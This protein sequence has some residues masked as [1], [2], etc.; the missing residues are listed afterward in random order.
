MATRCSV[1]WFGVA[2]WRTLPLCTARG[3]ILPLITKS[4]LW[5]SLLRLFY[6]LAVFLHIAGRLFQSIVSGPVLSLRK[7]Q[8]VADSAEAKASE[9]ANKE[10]FM[11]SNSCQYRFLDQGGWKR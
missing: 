6:L 7:A 3:S 2:C 4:R 11:A 5:L 1:C 9:K 8:N 10:R